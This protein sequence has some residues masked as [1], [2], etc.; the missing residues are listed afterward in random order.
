MS[1]DELSHIAA[2]QSG[3]LTHFDPLYRDYV[4]RIYAYIYRRT[5]KKDLAE[6]LTSMTFMRALEK[7]DL[8]SPSKGVFAAW[9]YTLARNAISDHF[10]SATVKNEMS[11]EDIWDMPTT[12]DVVRTV[13]ERV[14]YDKLVDAL[15][16]LDPSKREIILLRL[17]D[18][19]PYSEIAAITGKTENNCKVMYSRTIDSLRQKLPLATF[20]LLFLSPPTL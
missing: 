14:T 19:L 2:C 15:K 13:D 18:N 9:L 17:W 6:D 11:V 12:D 16:T 20:L 8:Y 3:D 10:R 7:I 4:Q 5:L 1:A